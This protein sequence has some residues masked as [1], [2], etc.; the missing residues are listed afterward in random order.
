MLA[1]ALALALV[2]PAHAAP[3]ASTASRDVDNLSDSDSDAGSAASGSSKPWMGEVINVTA[4]GTVAD[5]P[6]ALATDVVSWQDSVAGPS[7]FQDLI[8]R[9]PGV[10]ATGQNGIFETFSIRGSGANGILVVV[11]GMPV[12]AQRR[13][14]VPVSFVEPSLLGEI[15]VTRGPA[16]VH[17]GPGAL[18]GAISIEPRWFDTAALAA[19]Y[20]SAGDETHFMGGFGT[21]FFSVAA[22]RHTANDTNSANGTPLNTSFERD[23]GSLQFRTQIAGFDVDGLLLPSRTENI[24]KSNSRFPTRDTTY[25]EDEHTLA[26]LRAR[27][28]NGFEVSLHGHDQA[29]FTRNRRP[30]AADTFASV[31]STDLGATVQ[32]TLH[33]GDFSHN[34][35]LEFLAR[36]DVNGYDATRV[37]ANRVYSLR[38]ATEE[39]WSIFGITDWQASDD[40][41]LE[42]GARFASQDQ[43]NRGAEASDSDAAFNAGAVFTPDE[44]QRWTLS[45]SSGFR[46]ATLEERFFTGVT[47]QGEI[48]GNPDLSTERSL[49][50]DLGHAWHN[51]NWN[52]E[53]HLWSTQVDDLISLFAVA[54]GVNGYTNV[55]DARL[56]GLDAAVAWMPTEALSLRASAT[57]VRSKD[58]R[59]GDPLYGSPPLTTTFEAKY[60]FADFTFGA[61][62]THRFRMKRPGFEEVERSA[63]DLIDL[64]L[65]WHVNPSMDVQLFVRNALDEDYFGTADVLSALAPERSF[66]VNV[67]W[68][69]R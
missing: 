43:E 4:K 25:P 22:A 33:S 56:H 39:N 8:V 16:V 52:T 37:I 40:F 26:R 14:G 35:G 41:A 5:L 45:V 65:R 31:E 17:F 19:G 69:L 46:F 54:P 61:F 28:D 21:E 10:G 18:G 12:T 32:H 68:A 67:S 62:Y 50:V 29:L 11:A 60:D 38:R 64:D 15:S 7:D 13:A 2:G 34:F 57:L 44:S 59:S 1:A 27:H 49:G 9:M 63:V 47:P 48:V 30:G 66:G 36:R 51:G 3:D 23:S 55:S 58:E 42:A 6:S 20:E 53:V 24:G